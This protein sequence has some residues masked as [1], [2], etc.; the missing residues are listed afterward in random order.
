[1]QFSLKKNHYDVFVSQFP[2]PLEC[3]W[4]PLNV[5]LVLKAIINHFRVRLRVNHALETRPWWRVEQTV[6]VN[7]T[8]E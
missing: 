8:T 1:M 7:I 5:S 4:Y 6:Q 2:V 3:T